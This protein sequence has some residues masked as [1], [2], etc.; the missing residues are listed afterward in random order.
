M[1]TEGPCAPS[2]QP[3]K[4][5]KRERK[6]ERERERERKKEGRKERKKE[7]TRGNQAFVELVLVRVFIFQGSFYT[8]SCP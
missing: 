2:D 4:D 8:L 3:E 5:S 7:L 6:K 1:N